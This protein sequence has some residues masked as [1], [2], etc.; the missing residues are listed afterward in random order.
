MHLLIPESFYVFR[1]FGILAQELLAKACPS[2]NVPK[3]MALD[4]YRLDHP[5]V[6]HAIGWTYSAACHYEH[7]AEHAWQL[8][9]WVRHFAVVLQQRVVHAT[10]THETGFIGTDHN[11]GN[12]GADASGLNTMLTFLVLIMLI[13]IW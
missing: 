9:S 11:N 1:H 3:R 4:D 8:G 5:C 2:I 6:A 12:D 13:I 7:L 10:K